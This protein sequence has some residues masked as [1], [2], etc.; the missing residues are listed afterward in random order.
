[1]TLE[2]YK[3]KYAEYVKKSE[4][5]RRKADKLEQQIFDELNKDNKFLKRMGY[6]GEEVRND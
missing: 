4:Y 3:A 5:Y 1:M 6:F 2:E